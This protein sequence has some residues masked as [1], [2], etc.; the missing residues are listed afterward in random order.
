MY[1]SQ[2]T[3]LR[4]FACMNTNTNDLYQNVVKHKLLA[5]NIWQDYYYTVHEIYTSLLLNYM[6]FILSMYK[7]EM[8]TIHDENTSPTTFR[9]MHTSKF[10][11]A[12]HE[13]N[14]EVVRQSP[15]ISN[16]WSQKYLTQN[17]HARVVASALEL[18]AFITIRW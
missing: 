2:A 8:T 9:P 6:W 10:F 3:C 14:H 4:Y 12:R 5:C 18:K 16:S 15:S 17:K 13:S 1:S 11:I 7:S